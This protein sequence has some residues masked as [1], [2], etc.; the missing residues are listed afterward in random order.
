MGG[1]LGREMISHL[2]SPRIR[3]LVELNRRLF[4]FM[5]FFDYFPALDRLILL[6]SLTE[7]GTLIL[8]SLDWD[9]AALLLIIL[10]STERG[11]RVGVILCRSS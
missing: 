10:G 3:R 6:Y 7:P 2:S 11:R 8:R 4:D 1:V 5:K 9:T